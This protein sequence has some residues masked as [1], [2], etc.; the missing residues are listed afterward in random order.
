MQFISGQPGFND[1]LRWWA[2]L[3]RTASYWYVGE[4]EMAR[5]YGASVE[6][7]P[8]Q[9]DQ[10]WVEIYLLLSIAS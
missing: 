10:E 8:K 4:D 2:D 9:Y 6:K 7:L 5:Q 3:I 1:C